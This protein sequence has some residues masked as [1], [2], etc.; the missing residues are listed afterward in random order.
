MWRGPVWA[1]NNSF[2]IEAL[3]KTRSKELASWR[4]IHTLE[5]MSAH[6]D[7]YEF[8]QGETGVP[9]DRAANIFGWSAAVFIDFAI[10]AAQQGQ[11]EKA[12]GGIE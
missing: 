4:V 5:M 10:R 11:L 7:I 3:E 1:N 6:A 2:F 12:Y 8:Y 9:Q